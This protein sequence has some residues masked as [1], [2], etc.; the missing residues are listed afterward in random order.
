MP[1]CSE[2]IYRGRIGRAPC[3]LKGSV[4]RGDKWYCR[5]HDPERVLTRRQARDAAMAK[6]T[7]ATEAAKERALD[8]ATRLGVGRP[9][10]EAGYGTLGT[11]TGGLVLTP[12]EV[13]HL[14]ERLTKG[15]A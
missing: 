15:G 6:R 8:L 9:H 3:S 4:Q 1:W 14:I 10:Y 12:S 11:Y 7:Q 5:H 13:E 2:T